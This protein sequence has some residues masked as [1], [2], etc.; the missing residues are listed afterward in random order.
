[1]SQVNGISGYRQLPAVQQTQN[2]SSKGIEA[3]SSVSSKPDSVEIS[4]TA[5]LLSKISMFPE[6]RQE[7]VE[8]IR[9]Q[10]ANGTYDIDGKLPEAIDK[11]LDD[12][13]W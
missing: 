3:I 9:T 5:Q 1:M 10:L 11:F 2:R 6:I 13:E 12:Y 4:P 7:K 8:E